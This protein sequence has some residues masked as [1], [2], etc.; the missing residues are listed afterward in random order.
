M[1]QKSDAKQVFIRYKAL[2]EIF[3][4][5]TIK[6]IYTDNGGEYEALKTYLAV[7]GITHL[8]TPP[9]TPQHNGLSERKHRHIVETFLT[10]L[11]HAHMPLEYW[12]HACST[13]AYLINRLP[14]PTL[15]NHSP[16]FKL[17]G[18]E[19]NYNKLRS[20]GCLCFPWLKPYTKHK[21][22]PKSK[23]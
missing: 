8:T 4:K 9:H 12:P 5:L 1:K 17:I 20:F 3:F 11:Y 22:E 15:K 18:T 23:P 19:P 14:T 21:L 16:Y 6:T 2:V 13:A 7:D 10:L